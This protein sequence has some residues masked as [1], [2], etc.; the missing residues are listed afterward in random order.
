MESF[1]RPDRGEGPFPAPAD[2]AP[3]SFSRPP[4]AAAP[5]SFDAANIDPT[6]D[7]PVAMNAPSVI[8]TDPLASE[9]AS[10]GM[11]HAMKA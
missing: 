1:D 7:A 10:W 2:A 8:P 9:L 5:P 6:S 11:Y 3:F 4:R